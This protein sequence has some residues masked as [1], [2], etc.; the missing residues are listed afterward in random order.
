MKLNHYLLS[1]TLLITSNSLVGQF[2]KEYEYLSMNPAI[3][4]GLGSTNYYGDLNSVYEFSGARS[5]TSSAHLFYMHP[6]SKAMFGKANIN[7]N[8]LGHIGIDSNIVKNFST[9]IFGGDLGVFYRLDNDKVFSQQQSISIFGGGGLGFSVFNVKTDLM[10]ENKQTYHYWSDGNIRNI[11]ENS[12]NAA[13]AILLNRD[14]DFET[15][16]I[17][18]KSN[19]PYLF[20]EAGVGLKVTHNL[21]VNLSYKHF[22]TFS[23]EIDGVTSN[24]KKDRFDNINLSIGWSFG[25]PFRT[26][27]EIIRDKEAETIDISDADEDGVYDLSDLCPKTPLGWEVDANGCPLDSDGDGVPDAIDEEPNS[28]KGAIVNKKGVTMSDEEIEVNYLLMTGQMGDH[29]RFNEWSEK[30][31]ELFVKYFGETKVSKSQSESEEE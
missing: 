12:P 22:F 31:P 16:V 14:Y 7:Y 30:Y 1:F 3:G 19:F 2:T 4:F 11:E 21:F 6:F 8:K 20:L 15:E 18:E 23:N 13:E 5:A 17:T 10:D 28:A 29:E 26:A 25:K 27:D 24:D 9:S